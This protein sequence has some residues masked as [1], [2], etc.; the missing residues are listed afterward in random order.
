MNQRSEEEIEELL[1]VNLKLARENNKI[2]RIMRRNSIISFWWR[3]FFF[4]ILSGGAY[5]T[6]M[7]YVRDY[8]L[9]IQNMYTSLQEGVDTVT[10]I[11]K[12]LPF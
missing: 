7:Y 2:L 1:K 11:P 6:Y 8:V 9:Q 3:V 10:S 4:L 12:K 5:Y